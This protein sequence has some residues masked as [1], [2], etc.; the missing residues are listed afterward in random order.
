MQEEALDWYQIAIEKDMKK[1]TLF[2]LLGDIK[3][4]NR[5]LEA[6]ISAIGYS[7]C[8]SNSSNQRESI[9]FNSLFQNQK[10]GDS[11][12][13][14]LNIQVFRDSEGRVI[15]D[16]E[17]RLIENPEKSLRKTDPHLL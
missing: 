7:H 15:R 13:E 16:S 1:S 10:E 9:P 8:L 2:E 17:G 5:N 14:C 4:P 12:G 3:A 6:N 11:K